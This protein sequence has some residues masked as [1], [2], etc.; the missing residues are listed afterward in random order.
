MSSSSSYPTW[1]NSHAQSPILLG[2]LTGNVKPS[3]QNM[4]TKKEKKYLMATRELIIN[5]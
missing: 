4:Q 3:S 5:Y 2:I 1:W